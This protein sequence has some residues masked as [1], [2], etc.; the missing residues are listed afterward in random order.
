MSEDRDRFDLDALCVRGD[1]DLAHLVVCVRLGVGD[2]HDYAEGGALGARREPLRPVDHPL[3]VLEHRRRSESGGIGPRDIGL[4]HREERPRLA[5]HK[6]PEVGV[7]LLLRAEK[8]EDLTV[9]GVGC[10]A[11]EDVLRPGDP[12]DLLVERGVGEKA[13]PGPARLGRQVG[14]PQAHL[15]GAPS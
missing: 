9:S 14:R 7:L 13:G 8:V 6:G 1:D 10:L 4:G 3:A 12:P 15:L 5:S 11:V 2:R